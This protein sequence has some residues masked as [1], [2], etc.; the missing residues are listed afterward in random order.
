MFYSYLLDTNT[1]SDFIKH[2]T[3]KIFSKIQEVGEEKICGSTA[4]FMIF[5]VKYP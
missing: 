2:P 5:S 4:P 1:L 3:G